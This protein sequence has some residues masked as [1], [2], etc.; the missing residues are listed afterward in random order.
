MIEGNSLVTFNGKIWVP[1]AMRLHLI[2]WYHENLQHAGVTRLLNTIEVHFGYPGI[3]KDLEELIRSCDI[4]QRHKITGKKQYGKIPLTPA[5][6]GKEPWEVVYINCTG[7]WDIQYKRSRG[8]NPNQ[9]LDLLT[10]SNACLG[11]VKFLVMKNKMAKHTAHLFDISFVN[12]L[13]LG[14]SS[15]TMEMNSLASNFKNYSKATVSNH[16]PLQ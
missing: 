15:M 11:W 10:I 1:A 5:L 4:C 9:K 12:I 2:K 14:E 13:N 8:R 6:W 7:P 3:R 16:N